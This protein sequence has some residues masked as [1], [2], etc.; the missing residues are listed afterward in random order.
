MSVSN[1]QIA[2]LFMEIA[3]L[4]DIEGANP[5]RIRAYRNAARSI[6]SY[7]RSM[8]ALVDEEFD[9]ST[10]RGIGKD[11]AGKITEIVQ[12]GK[13][14]FLQTLE[15]EVS[16]E[17]EELIKIP[18]LGPK[19]V[20]L[21]HETLHVNSLEE[22]Q[23][24]L[25]EGKVAQL[26]GFGPKLLDSIRRGLE[27]KLYEQKRYRLFEAVP[28]AESI[29]HA[30][31]DAKGLIAIETA[32]SIRRRRET[33][34]DIDIIASCEGENDIMQR[35]A[36][37]DETE[38]VLMQGPTR[39]SVELR[40][41]M[42]VDLRVVPRQAFGAAL[43]H[44]TGSKAHNIALRRMAA[45]KGLKINEYGL[46]KADK[47]VA[48]D[49]ETD[50]Y[51]TL[52]LAYVEPE[53]R[54][55]R[56][57]IEQAREHNLPKLIEAEQI[58]GDLHL[59]TDYTDGANSIKEMAIAA[60]AMGYEY[61]AVTDHTK[62][63]TIAHGLDE[64][65]IRQQLEEIDRI[66]E[67]LVG[68]TILKSAEVDILADGSLDLPDSVLKELDLTVCAVH[69]KL[70]LSKKEQTQR[71]LKAM[72]NLY[73]SI[74]AHPTGRLI[75]LR[76]AYE[77]DIETIIEACSQRGCILELNAQPDRLD[78]NDIH[79]KMAKDAGVPIAISTDAHSVRD[80][81]LMEYGIGQARR[82]WIE[83]ED[84]VNTK[85]LKELIKILNR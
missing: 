12:T 20:R 2:A 60:K 79:C 39:S 46:F 66:N 75:G 85:S 11:L 55:N 81:E 1:Q 38:R 59:H 14:V 32:G 78:L 7:P 69:Y 65:R 31:K 63:L 40:N 34:K 58:K 23:K 57:E 49:R 4:L 26:S 17:L 62:H 47:R 71:I 53:I 84:V 76:D 10:L 73:F 13:L 61:I 67:E 8:A 77:V 29:V 18:G 41:G 37:L 54:E 19:R 48:G 24:A 56:G 3:D 82:G 27:K 35:L 44:F 68:I 25:D 22:L 50:I 36:A 45:K 16:P 83:K 28:V 30:L 74:L 43:H 9:L 21:L 33:V 42:H 5:F 72:E 6:V 64:K 70:N 80:L 52:G 51:E 15:K